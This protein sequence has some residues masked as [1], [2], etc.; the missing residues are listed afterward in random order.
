M[1]F[2][3]NKGA[4]FTNVPI[5]I[6]RKKLEEKR[7]L[8]E[9]RA[10]DHTDRLV[11]QGIIPAEEAE[12]HPSIGSGRRVV[13][14]IPVE[15][16]EASARAVA[17]RKTLSVRV[18][19][20]LRVAGRTIARSELPPIRLERGAIS[21]RKVLNGFPIPMMTDENWLPESVME[22]V[23]EVLMDPADMVFVSE[24][25]Y[26]EIV[27]AAMGKDANSVYGRALR[28][29][30]HN[31]RSAMSHDENGVTTARLLVHPSSVQ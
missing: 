3:S 23:M 30:C 6:Q 13:V 27:R 19:H 28:K 16:K 15:R 26:Q 5:H 11:A 31:D 20:H 25:V 10:Q 29:V 22:A 21:N 7:R 18:G 17:E 12:E 14:D 2:G 8:M 24:L 4:I 1:S 9:E